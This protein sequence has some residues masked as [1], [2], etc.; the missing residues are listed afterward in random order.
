[1]FSGK[2]VI[3]NVFSNVGL[4]NLVPNSFVGHSPPVYVKS[5]GGALILQ[6]LTMH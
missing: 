2:Y 3:E 4:Y 5:E 1:M 6:A